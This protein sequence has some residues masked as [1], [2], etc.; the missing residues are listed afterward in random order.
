MVKHP[1]LL[2]KLYPSYLIVAL[3]SFCLVSWLVSGQ[4]AERFNE[5]II[6]E[7]KAQA[8]VVE[9]AVGERFSQ[10]KSSEVDAILKEMGS[11]IPSRITVALGSGDVLGDS[12]MK[13]TRMDSFTGRPEVE[14]AMGGT[15]GVS[16]R[17]SLT[18]DAN[19]IF[20]AIPVKAGDRVIGIIRAGSP[21][22]SPDMLMWTRDPVFWLILFVL[23]G[24][25]CWYRSRTLSR[26]IGEFQTAAERF[27]DT[28][29]A[30]RVDVRDTA[31]FSALTDS[32]NTMASQL[33]LK[34][35]TVI[36]Q[37]NELEAV[38]SGMMEAV[39][40]VDTDERIVR[41]NR[42]AEQ[43]FNIDKDK[44][45]QKSI[46]EAIRHTDFHRF[47]TGTLAC[48][49][50]LE[51][52]IVIIGDPDTFLQARGATLRDDRGRVTGALIV[53]NDVTRLKTLE[54]IRRDFVA[55]VSHELKTPITSIKG[56]LET[57]RDGAMKDP[58]NA[59]RFL[60]ICIRHTDRLN[61]IIEDLL[62][63]SRIERDA[64][65]GEVSLVLK[66]IQEV[67]DAV[68]RACNK[69][70]M[71]KDIELDFQVKSSNSANINPTLLE[72]AIVNLVDNAVKYS[73]PGKTVVVE[74]L[75]HPGE[76]VINVRDQGCGISKEHL[77]RIFERFYRVDKARSRKVGGTGLGLAI[78]KHIVH[79]HG[80]RVIVESSLGKG[81]VFSIHL[82]AG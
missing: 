36:R 26:A 4:L 56:F 5:R 77:N 21:S 60:D 24:I 17:M 44:V 49:D 18:L 52:D 51:G 43:L 46:Q 63:L 30:H 80:G 15:T 14:Q 2:W 76:L 41:I 31:E 47:V 23:P 62:S 48:A 20:V 59:E 32:F 82:P 33:N 67:L 53:L 74:A 10:D 29:F 70:A 68:A 12:Q 1:I 79:A 7:L 66:P 37:R 72:Q 6:D 50:P 3:F 78:V 65:R 13:I 45:K 8:I 42:A 73:E 81:S 75:D 28:D 57:L 11:R 69:K 16:S 9:K 25:A 71:E 61:A 40:V 55:N 19:M 39:M 38:L 35:S 34:L 54:I 58:E 22:V 64:E 27:S